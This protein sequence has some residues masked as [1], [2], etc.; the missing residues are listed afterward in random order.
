MTF[1]EL[2]ELAAAYALGSLDPGE[3]SEFE[4][5][6][7]DCDRCRRDVADYSGVVEELAGADSITPPPG[8]RSRVLDEIANTAQTGS[9]R[10]VPPGPVLDLAKARTRRIE[11]RSARLLVAAAAAV[12]LM[13]GG[14]AAL[15]TLGNRDDPFDTV[16][17]APDAE[18]LQLES[19]LGTVT[20]VYSPDL[21]RVGVLSTDLP[22][23]GEGM[24]YELWL[25]V[26]DGVAPAGLFTPED[27][28]VRLVLPVDDID[29]LGFGISIEPE[30]GSDQPTDIVLLG[31]F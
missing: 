9:N 26:D 23:P 13:I 11:L 19:D 1:E 27:G 8:L 22:D 21:D 31:S 12:M 6:L 24:T 18:T 7:L 5:H 14:A 4:N 16:V 10:S 17:A 3:T 15:L 25:V 29:T 2:H 30:G 20:V 28:N